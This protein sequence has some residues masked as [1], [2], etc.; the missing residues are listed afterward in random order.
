[1]NLV[2]DIL[3]DSLKEYG[4]LGAVVFMFFYIILSLIQLVRDVLKKR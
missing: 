4:G 2:V 3:A 1:M